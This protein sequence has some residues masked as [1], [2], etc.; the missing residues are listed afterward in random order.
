MVP[1]ETTGEGRGGF[2]GAE[3]GEERDWRKGCSWL[4]GLKSLRMN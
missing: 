3:H 1:E 2:E 4:A